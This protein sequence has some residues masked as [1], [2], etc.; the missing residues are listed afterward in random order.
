MVML[1]GQSARNLFEVVRAVVGAGEWGAGVKGLG[2]EVWR[3]VEV[4][5]STL[6]VS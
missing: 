1:G 5:G 2:W 4:V 3:G 6:G